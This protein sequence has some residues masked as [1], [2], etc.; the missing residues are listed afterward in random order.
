MRSLIKYIYYRLF[1]ASCPDCAGIMDSVL[2][3]EYDKLH[4]TCRKCKKEWL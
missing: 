4:Y 1:F 3:M 2:N